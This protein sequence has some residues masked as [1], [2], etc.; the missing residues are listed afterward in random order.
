MVKQL[1]IIFCLFIAFTTVMYILYTQIT[2]SKDAARDLG[3]HTLKLKL[4]T[5][6]VVEYKDIRL[7]RYGASA[8]IDALP[9][10]YVWLIRVKEVGDEKQSKQ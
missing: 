2:N 8:D 9:C 1:T 5:Q 10:D 7:V 6:E 3:H 4:C